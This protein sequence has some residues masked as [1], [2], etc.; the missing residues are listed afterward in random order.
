MFDDLDGWM[1]PCTITGQDHR[2]DL[3]VVKRSKLYVLELKVGF[4]TNIVINS[5]RKQR[6]YAELIKCLES[7]YE[8][9]S[10]VNVSIGTIGVFGKSCDSFTSMLKLKHHMHV[11]L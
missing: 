6:K 11:K 4:E 5:E 1:S 3:L 7:S 10:F 9:V 8:K 2:L